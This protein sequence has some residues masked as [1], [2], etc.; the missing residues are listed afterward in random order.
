MRRRTEIIAAWACLVLFAAVIV[1]WV[2]GLFAQDRIFFSLFDHYVVLTSY[3]HHAT[4]LVQRNA[5]G[6][7]AS[8]SV[9]LGAEP[10]APRMRF[11]ELHWSSSPWAWV[12]WLPHWVLV[13]L[14][15]PLPLWMLGQ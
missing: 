12:V 9:A 15:G 14:F 2:R 8:F 7:D 3:P 5:Y 4:I 11:L 10:Y 6:H 13:L 1:I